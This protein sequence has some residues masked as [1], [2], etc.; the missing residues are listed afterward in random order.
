MA[1]VMS[2][3]NVRHACALGTSMAIHRQFSDHRCANGCSP[4]E[5]WSCDRHKQNECKMSRNCTAWFVRWMKSI[6]VITIAEGVTVPKLPFQRQQEQWMKQ[7]RKRK[8]GR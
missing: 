3:A 7:M 6:P 1:R 8:N 5:M 2:V 4:E